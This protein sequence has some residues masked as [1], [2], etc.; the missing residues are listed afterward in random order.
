MRKHAVFLAVLALVLPFMGACEEE[1]GPEPP[2]I[3]GSWEGQ[4]ADITLSMSV[5]ENEDGEVFGSGSLSSPAISFGYDV[6]GAHAFPIV[7][8]DLA[9]TTEPEVLSFDG[10]IAFDSVGALL[11]LEGSLSGGGFDR[12]PFELTRR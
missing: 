10:V 2:L 5:F 11:Q 9:L 1:V 3:T 6:T 8:L 12:S 4:S 7:Q